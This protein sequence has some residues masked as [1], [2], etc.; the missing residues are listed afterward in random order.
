MYNREDINKALNAIRAALDADVMDADINSVDNKLKKL[1]QLTGLSAEANASAQK[2]L[3][4]KELEIFKANLPKGYQA[5]VLNNLIKAESAD[6][7]ALYEYADRL[8]AALVHSLDG[9]R[10]S[11][12]LYKA[13]LQS[14]LIPDGNTK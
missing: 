9:L 12:S 8:N 5:S 3:R 1:T 7:I 10:T 13:E 2:I 6:E 14:G 11:I 4:Q